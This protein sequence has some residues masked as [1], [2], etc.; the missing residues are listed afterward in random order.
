MDYK[1][2]LSLFFGLFFFSLTSA[3]AKPA[4]PETINKYL[5]VTHSRETFELL[6]EIRKAYYLELAT[7]R[8]LYHIQAPTLDARLL[9]PQQY[10]VAERIAALY[11]KEDPIFSSSEKQYQLVFKQLQQYVSEESLLYFIE[12]YQT[13]S[14]QILV[15]KNLLKELYLADHLPKLLTN[16]LDESK[17][18]LYIFRDILTYKKPYTEEQ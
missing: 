16:Y 15:K 12:H 18:M 1:Y 6:H 8:V 17:F 4:K 11:L 14:G 7:Q 9:T 5:E 10:Q 13:E 3:C 2:T